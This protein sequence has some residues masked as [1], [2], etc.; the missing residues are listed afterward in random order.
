MLWLPRAVYT[1]LTGTFLPTVDTSCKTG[2]VLLI[3]FCLLARTEQPLVLL[4]ILHWKLVTPQH[5][6]LHLDASNT[7]K[8][9]NAHLIFSQETF[10]YL[11]FTV[12]VATAG[13][14]YISICLFWLPLV[15]RRRSL[16]LKLIWIVWVVVIVAIIVWFALSSKRLSVEKRLA[17]YIQHL[18]KNIRLPFPFSSL[19]THNTKYKP[20]YSIKL[21]LFE[22]DFSR[23]H[24]LGLYKDRQLERLDFRDSMEIL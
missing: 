24:Q 4:L 21:C 11:P 23:S 20:A 14:F 13:M 22:R 18:V 5:F 10:A 2:A 3:A 1:S 16:E 19:Q 17:G 8:L 12:C 9:F 7:A 15:H 6:R